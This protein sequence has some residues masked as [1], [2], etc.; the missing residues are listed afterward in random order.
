MIVAEE[1]ARARAAMDVTVRTRWGET[2]WRNEP[3][4]K[5][6]VIPFPVVVG[7]ELCERPAQVGFPKEQ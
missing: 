2:F 4:V 1:P 7:Y 5:A 6:L 3:I